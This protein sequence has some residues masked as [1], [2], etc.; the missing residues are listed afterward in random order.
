[1]KKSYKTKQ[2][3][4]KY[5]KISIVTL[6]ILCLFFEINTFIMSKK[7]ISL[8]SH[9]VIFKNISFYCLNQTKTQNNLKE[10]SPEYYKM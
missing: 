3:K 7:K 2:N 6:H 4:N 9:P 8:K 10:Y 1:M 5:I